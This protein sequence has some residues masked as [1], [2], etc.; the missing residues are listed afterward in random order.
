[1]IGIDED[2]VIP[3]KSLSVYEG[4]IVCWRGEKMR[5]WNDQLVKTAY[6]FDF[7]IHRPVFELTT[8]ERALCGTE[9]SIS[10]GYGSFRMGGDTNIQDPVPGDAQ[11]V[12]ADEPPVRN[13]AELAFGKTRPM[14]RSPADRSRTSC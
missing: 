6:K 8:E 3:D 2:L 11:A 7:P 13:A 14:S 12:T 1:M 5:E 9:T 10:K 4:A